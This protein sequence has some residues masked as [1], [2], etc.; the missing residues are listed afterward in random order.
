[1][2][3][4]LN[5]IKVNLLSPLLI[6][7]SPKSPILHKTLPESGGLCNKM[8]AGFISLRFIINYSRI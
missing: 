1:M 4:P 8:F 5:V 3:Y 2:I 7:T 6:L